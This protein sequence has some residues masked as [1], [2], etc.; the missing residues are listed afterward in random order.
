MSVFV[1][2]YG[3]ILQDVRPALLLCATG[4]DG[5]RGAAS[6]TAWTPALPQFL[7]APLL[8][9]MLRPLLLLLARLCDVVVGVRVPGGAV[10]GVVAAVVPGLAEHVVG[11]LQALVP[12][13]GRLQQR[14]RLPPALRHL[15]VC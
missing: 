10:E 14:R 7:V 13:A 9:V 6:S 8:V 2:R 1:R 11:Y 12:G 5:A 15:S 4:R 3:D